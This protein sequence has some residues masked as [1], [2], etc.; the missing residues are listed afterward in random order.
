MTQSEKQFRS[1]GEWAQALIR[2][3]NSGPFDPRLIRAPAGAGETSATGG[4]FLVPETNANEIVATLY[5][6][7]ASILNYVRRFNIPDGYN[8]LNVNGVDET[9]RANGYRWGG[10]SADFVDEGDDPS[11]SFPRI[12]QTGFTASKIIGKC[13]VTAEIAADVENL[14]DFLLSAFTDELEYKL[15]QYIL[16]SAGTGVSRPLSVM[17]SPALVTVPKTAAQ[18]ASTVSA[19]NLRAMWAALPAGSR[20]R[21]IWAVAESVTEIVESPNEI[22]YAVSG[23]ANPDDTPRIMGRPVIQT[24]VLPAIGAVGDVLLIDPKWIGFASKPLAWAMS[25]DVKFESDQI[26]FRITWR[27]NAKPLVST[28]LLGSDGATRSAF[29]ALAQRS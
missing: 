3:G 27:C 9:S 5:Q 18:T 17:N 23:S 2:A 16:S 20:K 24:D 10:L 6:D 1:L 11:S 13:V 8:T 22:T 7:R 25:A 26:V 12:M 21:A 14:G 4:G 15:E 29:V 19:A 28:T